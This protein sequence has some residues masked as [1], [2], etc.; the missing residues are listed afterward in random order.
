MRNVAT[1][2]WGGTDHRG[3]Q[4]WA[5]LYNEDVL[6]NNKVSVSCTAYADDMFAEMDIRREKLAYTPNSKAWLTNEYEHNGLRANGERILD[7]LTEP[8]SE[9]DNQAT[10]LIFLIG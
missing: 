4:D 7:K 6:A 9:T 1:F 3:K 5:N 2:E 8:W 10:D